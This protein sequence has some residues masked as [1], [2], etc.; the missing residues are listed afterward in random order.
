MITYFVEISRQGYKQVY[1]KIVW[2]KFCYFL[3]HEYHCTKYNNLYCH[4]PP[5]VR[6]LYVSQYHMLLFNHCTICTLCS[7][8]ILLCNR[9]GA[10]S[11]NWVSR[12]LCS[13]CC[14][15]VRANSHIVTGLV[16]DGSGWGLLLARC[17][18]M[19]RPSDDSMSTGPTGNNSKGI[20]L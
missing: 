18:A 20:L 9:H 7:L 2:Y 6:Y 4:R 5:I 8:Y 10:H 1:C 11:P 12:S 15:I 19:A 14:N 13:W 3:L 16:I 17:L